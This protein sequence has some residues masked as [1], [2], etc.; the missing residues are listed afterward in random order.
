M[1]SAR[2][3]NSRF[4]VRAA[5]VSPLI[6]TSLCLGSLVGCGF[7]SEGSRL[8]EDADT[9]VTT[10]DGGVGTTE[11]RDPSPGR[12][13]DDQPQC[14]VTEQV[15]AP[16]SGEFALNEPQGQQFRIPTSRDG[17]WADGSAGAACAN[18]FRAFF[19]EDPE[20]RRAAD[21]R[22]LE[23]RRAVELLR[24]LFPRHEG[25]IFGGRH[26]YTDAQLRYAG[27]ERVGNLFRR[28]P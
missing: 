7:D 6:V 18:I 22:L 26:S 12:E 20:A 3:F 1:E 27:I 15:D 9:V 17:G 10:G 4:F 23:D 8:S 21:A 25:V 13:S 11:T 24:S 19:P 16:E 2:R 5:L 14:P 28:I